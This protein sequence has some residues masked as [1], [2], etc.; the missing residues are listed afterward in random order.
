MSFKK[1]EETGVGLGQDKSSVIQEARVF[2]ET[3]VSPRKCRILLTKLLYLLYGG[4][5]FSRQEG[6][7][8]FFGATKL[9]QHKDAA[10]RQMTYLSIKELTP[11]SDDTIMIIASILKDMQPNTE[12]IYRP[13]AIRALTRVVD[14]SMVQGLERFFKTAILDKNSFISSAA[15]VSSYH[16]NIGSR[17]VVKRWANEASEAI[18]PKFASS[19]PFGGSSGGGGGGGFGGAGGYLGFAASAAG[20]GSSGSPQGPQTIASTSFMTQYHALGLL[21]LIRQGDRMA[22]SKLIQQL[23]SG[24]GGSSAKTA[25]ALRSPY[26]ICMLVRFAARLAEEDPNMRGPMTALLEDWLRHKSDMVNYEAARALCELRG[27]TAGELSRPVGVLQLFLS[28]PKPTLKFAAIRTLAKLAHSHPAAVQSCNVDMEN[29]ITD[30]NR[31]VATYAIT[32]LLKTGNEASVDRLMKQISGFM[33]EI[34]D[35]FKV[36]VVDAIRSLC[37]KFPSKQVVMLGFLSSVLRDEGGYEFKRAVVE[38]IFD[39]VRFIGEC[40]EAAL[41]HLCEFIEDC[42]FTKIS[43]RILH[44]LGVEGPKMAQPHK[45]IRYIYNRVILENAI[46]RAAAVASLA[47]FGIED[48]TLNGRIKVLLE[49][50]L[51]D[52]DDEVRD[53]AAMY[54]RIL[55]EN[56][57]ATRLVRDDET[58]QLRALESSLSSYV[59]EPAQSDVPFDA[60]VVPKITREEAELEALRAKSEATANVAMAADSSKS[61]LAGGSGAGPSGT[62]GQVAD[63]GAGADGLGSGGAGASGRYASELAAIPQMAGYG[64]LLKSSETAAELTERETEYVVSAIKHVFAEH[65]VFQYNVSNT[66]PDTVLENVAVV[67]GGAAD[68]GLQEDFILTIDSLSASNP[69]GIVYVSFTRT[70]GPSSFPIGTLQN[71]LRFVSKEVDPSSGEPEEEGYDDEYQTEDLELGVADYVVPRYA[72]FG[73]EWDRMG[74][75]GKPEATETFALTALDSLKTACSTLVDLLGMQPSGGSELPS[76]GSVHTLQL[77]GTVASV[78]ESA[79]AGKAGK[80]AAVLARARMTFEE[81]EGVNMEL[82]VRAEDAAAVELIIGAI[83]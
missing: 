61:V 20:Y 32:T 29:L 66:V 5:T 74:K 39:M 77:S 81:G 67:V 82:S 13:N 22:I 75:E 8:L 50:C 52:V 44:L 4:E 59:A 72:N 69:S 15:L 28:S 64:P 79:G 27:I 40:K 47:K 10:L 16:L 17:D 11:I 45:Y 34:S 73:Q 31:S 6:T 33:S 51:D 41:A 80:G 2:N 78:N 26:A 14:P 30:P 48:K 7:T 3:P 49:R 71:T 60:S 58:Y 56:K 25:S 62:S 38:A 42:E 55:A 24:G 76:S 18:N 70:D 46:V 35:E 53:R 43:V 36:I 1:D 54:L 9:F 68:V 37:L 23:G 19:G 65:I 57:L 12:V 63:S 21:Y 83:A